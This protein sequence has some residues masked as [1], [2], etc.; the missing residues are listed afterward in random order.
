MSR[1]ALQLPPRFGSVPLLDKR[2]SEEVAA[3]AERKGRPGVER[4]GLGAEARLARYLRVQAEQ[5][6]HNLSHLELPSE[7]EVLFFVSQKDINAYTLL[8]WLLE[9]AGPAEDL[10]LTS[11][12]VNQNIIRAFAGLLDEPEGSPRRVEHLSLVLSACIKGR[13]P[14]R[15][16]EL[17]Q[18]WDPRRER[19]RISMCWNHSKVALAHMAD[20]RRFVV[21]GSGN[22]SFNAEIEQYEV[23][24]DAALHEWLRDVLDQRTFR[25]RSVRRHYVWGVDEPEGLYDA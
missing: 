7:G 11:F 3:E 1:R 4:A 24:A 22:Y 15:V 18:A 2:D 9:E 17:R 25:D 10:F 13:M 6:G 20:G 12:N 14:A 5:V 21:T 8:L 23:W 19:W 16:D